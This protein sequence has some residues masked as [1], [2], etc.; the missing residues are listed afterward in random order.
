[1]LPSIVISAVFIVYAAIM[2]VYLFTWKK[3]RKSSPISLACKNVFVSVIVPVRNEKANILTLLNSLSQQSYLKSCFEV[4]IVNDHSDD[5]TL[6]LL[7]SYK[8]EHPEVN[9]LLLSLTDTAAKKA[10][11][12][13]GVFAAKGELILTTDADCT[14][15]ETW[16]ERIAGY[17]SE[18][19]PQLI[20]APVLI[21]GNDSFFPHF[22]DIHRLRGMLPSEKPGLL[23]CI[24]MADRVLQKQGQQ[25]AL[26]YNHTVGNIGKKN[27][28]QRSTPEL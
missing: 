8:I 9:I 19:H 12:T 14:F 7:E 27:H 25:L 22:P 16:L 20:I 2:M 4:I 26:P 23:H 3:I 13:A 28:Y 17:Y 15:N 21:S 24:I 18:F 6:Q 11:I 10:A 5:N 1:M